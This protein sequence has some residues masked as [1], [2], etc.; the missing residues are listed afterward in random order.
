MEREEEGVMGMD[1]M[2]GSPF[3]LSYGSVPRP[4]GESAEPCVYLIKKPK[5]RGKVRLCKQLPQ[6]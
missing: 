2:E 5:N 1:T 4:E 6:T 3:E